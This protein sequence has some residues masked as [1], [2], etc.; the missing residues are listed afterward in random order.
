MLCSLVETC[1]PRRL[2][3]VMTRYLSTVMAKVD[4]VEEHLS[5]LRSGVWIYIGRRGSIGQRDVLQNE[6]VVPCTMSS[7]ACSNAATMVGYS[8]STNGRAMPVA[9]RRLRM[10]LWV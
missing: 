3:C 6:V 4:G 1:I 10:S 8:L 2:V 5:L 7:I 9:M